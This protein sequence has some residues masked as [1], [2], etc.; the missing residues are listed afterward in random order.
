LLFEFAV[1]RLELKLEDEDEDC[2]D[3]LSGAFDRLT[4]L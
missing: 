2:A 4:D 3:F 1:L